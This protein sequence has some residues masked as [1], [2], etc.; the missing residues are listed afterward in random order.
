MLLIRFIIKLYFHK[1]KK[2]YN[3]DQKNII[4]NI[5]LNIIKYNKYFKK[6]TK[7]IFNI[8]NV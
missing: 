8:F 3:E 2:Y 7:Y 6:E 4:I 5:I 1:I